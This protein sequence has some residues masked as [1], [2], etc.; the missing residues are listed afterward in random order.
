M[1]VFKTIIKENDVPDDAEAIGKDSEL[2]GITEMPVD[3]LLFRIGTG[4]S[5]GRHEPISHEIRVDIRFVLI[6]SLE[7]PD[8]GIESFGVIFSNIQLNAGGIKGEHLGQG[9]ID[10]L[11]DGLSKVC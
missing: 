8:K 9:G 5:L 2:V 6:I 1:R 10:Q 4:G 7:P 11:A 3:V